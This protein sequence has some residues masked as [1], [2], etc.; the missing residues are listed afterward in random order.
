MLCLEVSE[1]ELGVF[2]HFEPAVLLELRYQAVEEAQRV[3]V[4]DHVLGLHRG[5]LLREGH[6]EHHDHFLGLL[7]TFERLVRSILEVDELLDGLVM[8]VGQE[9][10][11]VEC[12]LLEEGASLVEQEWLQIAHFTVESDLDLM[13]FLVELRL[14]VH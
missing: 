5:R 1:G 10:G 12:L 9:L 4:V 3:L 13:D 7:G 2:E 8:R 11:H 6:L 14:L